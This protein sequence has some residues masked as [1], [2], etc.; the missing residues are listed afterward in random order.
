MLLPEDPL[1]TRHY[2]AASPHA[3]KARA[4]TPV[5]VRLWCCLVR[6]VKVLFRHA[7]SGL[8]RK[9]TAS[10]RKEVGSNRK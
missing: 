6:E 1:V 2:G 7:F 4:R 9:V 3:I 5:A 8:K 10:L